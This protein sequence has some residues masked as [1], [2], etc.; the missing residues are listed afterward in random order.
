MVDI[1][2]K[3]TLKNPV[4]YIDFMDS[5]NNFKPTRKDFISYESAKKWINKTMDEFH[6]NYDLINQY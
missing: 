6:R 5:K 2:Y 4:C 3:K 1:L